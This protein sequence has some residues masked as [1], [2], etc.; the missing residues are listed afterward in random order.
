MVSGSDPVE[1]L[2]ESID[3]AM[4]PVSI[5]GPK[6]C[7]AFER[8]NSTDIISH[9]HVARGQ[10]TTRTFALPRAARATWKLRMAADDVLFA[11]DFQRTTVEAAEA[12]APLVSVVAKLKRDTHDGAFAAEDGAAGTLT[13]TFSNAHAWWKAKT[14]VFDVQ[15]SDGDAVAEMAAS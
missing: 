11:V 4:L 9:F 1:E 12:E 5:G 8:L 2:S 3:V 6:A 15:S 13:F 14:V 7:P 10:V